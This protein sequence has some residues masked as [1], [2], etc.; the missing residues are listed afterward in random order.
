[1]RTPTTD[2]VRPPRALRLALVSL[3]VGLLLLAGGAPVSAATADEQNPGGIGLRLLDAPVSAKDDPRAR[4][5]VVD[6]LAPGAVIERRV[7]VAN[8]TDTAQELVLYPAAATIDDGTF[9]GAPGRELNDLASWTSVTADAATVPAG[10][11][12]IAVVRIVVPD[13]AAPGEQ[14]GVVWAEARSDEADAT[15]VVQ[16]SRVGIRLYVSVG[17]GGPPAADFEIEALTAERSAD[18]APVVAAIVRNTGGRALD[19]TGT[20][21]L[22]NG[23]GGLTAGPF[24]AELGRTLAIDGSEPVRVALD[25]RLPDGPW[26]AVITLESGLTQRTGEATITFSAAGDPVPVTEADDAMPWAVLLGAGAVLALLV[27]ATWSIRR[28]RR[29]RATR[30][31]A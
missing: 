8:T 11:T 31:A 9:V 17:P 1:M 6:H 29:R 2:D 12:E 7:E 10:G 16:V 19:M 26:D 20:L 24:P 28:Q 5:Y 30:P 23:P 13:D 3:T 22:S 21:Q 14:Y 15:G 18:G 25:E 27:G 4:I